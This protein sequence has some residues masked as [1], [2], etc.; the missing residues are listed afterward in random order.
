MTDP[1]DG[2]VHHWFE[3]TYSNYLVLPRTLL[4]SMPTAWQERIVA[5]LGELRDAYSHLPQAEGYEVHAATEHEVGDLND[6]QLAELGITETW[7]GGATPPDGLDAE[8][9]KAWE[10]EHMGDGPTYDRDGVELDADHRV[11]LPCPDPVPHYNRGRT[12]IP[13]QP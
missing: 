6:A 1:T 13:P 4:Q 8:Q 7:Y 10:D 3:L 12:Y 9:L 11:L 5:C 2:P